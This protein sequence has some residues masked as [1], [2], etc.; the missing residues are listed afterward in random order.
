MKK[1][2]INKF[3]LFSHLPRKNFIDF[4][5]YKNMVGRIFKG[6]E[7][8]SQDTQDN[9][10]NQKERDP[11]FQGEN[12]QKNAKPSGREN[13]DKEKDKQNLERDNVRKDDSGKNNKK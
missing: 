9:Q 2:L 8:K 5:K 4:Q 3:S 10:K 6:E 13:L 7:M 12:Q 11:S 1:I